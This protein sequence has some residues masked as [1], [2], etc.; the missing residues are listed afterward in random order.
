[1]REYVT[2]HYLDLVDFY[3]RASENTLCVIQYIS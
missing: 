2:D 3:A 1:D